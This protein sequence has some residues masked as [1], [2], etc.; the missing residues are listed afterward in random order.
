MNT[1]GVGELR[2]QEDPSKVIR[3]PVRPWKSG[4]GYI[5]RAIFRNTAKWSDSPDYGTRILIDG[6][7]DLHGEHYG[8]ARLDPDRV[9][10][11]KETR[12]KLVTD[13]NKERSACLETFDS[14][15]ENI[16]S[17]IKSSLRLK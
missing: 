10:E 14:L 11:S 17:A 7:T 1:G 4:I 3:E 9:Y 12:N 16:V 8:M 2:D 15:D 13:L 5:T 6:V